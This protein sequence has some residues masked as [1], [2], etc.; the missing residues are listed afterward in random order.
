MLKILK[1]IM[2]NLIK[3][4]LILLILLCSTTLAAQEDNQVLPTGSEITKRINARDE[5]ESVTR[6]LIMELIDRR[7]K[8]RLRE[9]RGFRKYYGDEKRTVLFYTSPKNV[10]DT[11]FLTIDYAEPDKDDD[12][13]LYLPAL[14]K[15]RRIS[16]SNRGDYFLGTDFTYE[17]IKKETKVDI[18]DYKRTTIGEEEIDG[19]KCY[20]VEGVPVDEKTAKELGYS[21]AQQWVDVEIWITRKA[22]MWDIKGNLLKTVQ[23]SDIRKVQDIWTIHQ[24]DAENHKTGHSTRFIFKDV[25]YQ[26]EVKDE[27]FTEQALRRGF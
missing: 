25:D 12:Q 26:S 3:T 15:V 2:K 10:K 24:M 14:R 8:K 11:A 9:T 7:G 18:K 20:I 6:T 17:D 4:V 23:F 16:A 5:G 1:I 22:I 27:L 19:H 13:W 21:K